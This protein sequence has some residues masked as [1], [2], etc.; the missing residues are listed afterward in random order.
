MYW[1][2]FG[3]RLRAGFAVLSISVVARAVETTVQPFGIAAYVND[4]AI[5]C[6]EVQ[7]VSRDL[8]VLPKEAL[9]F[10]IEQKLLAFDFK[11]KGGKISAMH[12]DAQVET[13]AKENFKGN[14]ELMR[15]VL[16]QQGQSLHGLK[17]D[18]RES[19]MFQ[20]MQQG[21]IPSKVS[22]SPER[23]HKYY[24][25]HASD[26][27]EEARY[28]L[29]QSGFKADETLEVPKV[30]GRA[31]TKGHETMK[32][33]AYLQ[34]LLAQKMPLADIQKQLDTFHTEAI[35]Y[36]ASELDPKL[37]QALEALSD[38]SQTPYLRIGDTWVT[39]KIIQKTEGR[40]KPL[41]EVQS[42]IEA[43]V[44]AEIGKEHYKEYLQRLRERTAI[45]VF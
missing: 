12:V 36:K 35:E 20:A 2:G 7:K 44:S 13:M 5:T 40:L 9:K 34:Q 38:G 26:F 3:R 18:I 22:V 29:E 25:A 15:Q 42:F 24:E 30:A 14:R 27:R 37:V 33:E 8:K 31:N 16:R 19:M 11:K 4:E 39:S 32:K 43:Q 21:R 28:C 45:A 10:L 23:I 6:D 17:K 1:S 41:Q